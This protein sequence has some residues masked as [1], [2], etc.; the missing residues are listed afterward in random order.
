MR[1]IALLLIC[2]GCSAT[3][4]KVTVTRVHGE[5]VIS[6]EFCANDIPDTIRTYPDVIRP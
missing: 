4:T 5:P 2:T 6:L 1:W 3:R